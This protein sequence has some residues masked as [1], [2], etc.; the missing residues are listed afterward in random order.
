MKKFITFLFISLFVSQI[1]A[2][3]MPVNLTAE[4]PTVAAPG[5]DHCQE[6]GLFGI[7]ED[8]KSSSNANASHYC[9]AV[10]AI[11]TTPPKFFASKQI[12]VYLHGDASTTASNIAESIFKPPRNYL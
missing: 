9:C 2:A 4:V 12:D 1:N 6:A 7:N 11:L 5:H 10:V 3:M 8:G